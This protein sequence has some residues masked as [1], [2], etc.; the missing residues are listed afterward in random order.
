LSDWTPSVAEYEALEAK[1]KRERLDNRLLRRELEWMKDLGDRTLRA[2]DKVLADRAK[3][4]ED[5]RRMV[6][7]AMKMYQQFG[8]L[9]RNGLDEEKLPGEAEANRREFSTEP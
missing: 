4:N 1:L 5:M 7:D 3:E 9:G 2:Y 6:S 8:R